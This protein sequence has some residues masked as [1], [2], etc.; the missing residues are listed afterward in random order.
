MKV[1]SD[2]ETQWVTK[3]THPNY[4]MEHPPFRVYVDNYVEVLQKDSMSQEYPEATWLTEYHL[5]DYKG[6]III[7]WEGGEPYGGFNFHPTKRHT[8]NHIK[9]HHKWFPKLIEKNPEV[10]I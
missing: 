6:S 9:K 5:V 3:Q 1:K 10:L 2:R 4:P 7:P 8:N